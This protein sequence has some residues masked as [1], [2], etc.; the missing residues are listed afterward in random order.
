MH[1]MQPNNSINDLSACQMRIYKIPLYKVTHNLQSWGERLAL[2]HPLNAFLPPPKPPQLTTQEAQLEHTSCKS[3]VV[4]MSLT[5]ASTGWSRHK[6]YHEKRASRFFH[7]WFKAFQWASYSWKYGVY[8]DQKRRSW[9]TPT[10]TVWFPIKHLKVPV[11]MGKL[12]QVIKHRPINR[13]PLVNL[14]GEKWKSIISSTDIQRMSL[15]K[16]GW[17]LILVVYYSKV[18]CKYQTWFQIKFPRHCSYHC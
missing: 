3:G 18:P 15:P 1:L 14:H 6:G 9:T 10:P 16:A 13:C 12:W 8:L 7:D 4:D 2:S 5:S 11:A 17:H